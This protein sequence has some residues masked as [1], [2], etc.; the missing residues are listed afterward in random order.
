MMPGL[1]F[2]HLY[3]YKPQVYIH[4]RTVTPE[5]RSD[6]GNCRQSFGKEYF[7]SRMA[8]APALEF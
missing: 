2:R 7:N 8:E 3:A 6:S 5:A 1:S 4:V